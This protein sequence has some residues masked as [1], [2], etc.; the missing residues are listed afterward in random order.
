MA[1]KPNNSKIP[2]AKQPKVETAITPPADQQTN[3]ATGEP[4]GE[5]TTQPAKDGD[6]KPDRDRTESTPKAGNG[7]SNKEASRKPQIQ[8]RFEN[9]D[10]EPVE[11][12]GADVSLGKQVG[13]EEAVGYAMTQS[14]PVQAIKNLAHRRQLKDNTE[15]YALMSQRGFD[16]A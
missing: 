7:K 8:K 14:D 6:A 12:E 16:M 5:V 10:I 15:T 3:P 4:V 11:V 1:K 13:P 2:K 9:T